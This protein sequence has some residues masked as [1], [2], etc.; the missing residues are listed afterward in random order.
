VQRRHETHRHGHRPE[1]RHEVAPGHRRAQRSPQ[2]HGR[3]VAL[4][5]T[6]RTAPEACGTGCSDDEASFGSGR[7]PPR[8]A[9]VPAD[10]GVRIPLG[11]TS[12]T[13]EARTKRSC[14]GLVRR[15]ASRGMRG[16]GANIRHEHRRARL[17]RRRPLQQREVLRGP[18]EKNGPARVVVHV[19][20][21][22]RS[23]LRALGS[24]PRSR[25]FA[26]LAAG[27][28]RAHQA[29]ARQHVLQPD[30]EPLGADPEHGRLPIGQAVLPQRSGTFLVAHEGRRS[31]ERT[32]ICGPARD[33][34]ARLQAT[35]ELRRF[36]SSH[37]PRWRNP[38][39]DPRHVGGS[40][41]RRTS[42]HRRQ[43]VIRPWGD[44]VQGCKPSQAQGN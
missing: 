2:I 39:G 19:Q 12:S 26:G 27:V 23:L 11:G 17:R 15:V 6:R 24:H 21:D 38:L 41:G 5:V 10:S 34:A 25:A 43:R 13:F 18:R 4:L 8:G 22:E 37:V 44:V 31:A 35:R 40:A 7:R 3:W 1:E 32:R 33:R 28:Q 42:A 20:R 30:D 9:T 16:S 36:C 29:A 14:R